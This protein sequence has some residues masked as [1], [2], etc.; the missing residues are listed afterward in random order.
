MDDINI[1]KCR[2]CLSIVENESSLLKMTETFL[3]DNKPHKNCLISEIYFTFCGIINNENIIERKSLKICI[4]CMT[5]LQ[6]SFTFREL[7][8]HSHETL[9][10]LGKQSQI[11]EG[12]YTHFHAPSA[13]ALVKNIV[14]NLFQ[15]PTM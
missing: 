11:K 13:R 4:K 2:C 1:N 7:C 9:N 8:R 6:N 10:L 3:F 12:R 14:F 15:N 5:L